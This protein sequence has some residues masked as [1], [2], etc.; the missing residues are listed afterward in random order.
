[1]PLSHPNSSEPSGQSTVR[2]QIFEIGR[3]DLVKEQ[4]FSLVGSH[5]VQLVS[6]DP[7]LQSSL[8]SQYRSIVMQR[9]FLH[10]NSVISHVFGP[11][12]FRQNITFPKFPFIKT[13]GSFINETNFCLF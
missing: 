5:V 3:H 12:N 6:S 1:M 9:L 4:N 2:S 10:I 8:P 7:S 13:K 11:E